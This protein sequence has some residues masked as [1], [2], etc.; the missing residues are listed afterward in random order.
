MTKGARDVCRIRIT[1]TRLQ[2]NVLL[3]SES[4]QDYWED[5]FIYREL[6]NLN[7]NAN[8]IVNYLKWNP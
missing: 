6:K 2:T 4:K 3:R 5:S 7:V 8:S 1:D